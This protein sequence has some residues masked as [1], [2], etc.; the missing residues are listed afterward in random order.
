MLPMLAMAAGSMA[1]GAA[2]DAGLFG[3]P[4]Q[5]GFTKEDIQNSIRERGNEIDKFS[6]DLA[7]MRAQYMAQISGLQDAAYKRFGNDA[8]AGFAAKG[9]GVDS[10]AFSSALARAAIPMQADMYGKAFDT[11]EGNLKAVDAARGSLFTG[12]MGA[13]SAN[14]STPV[15][16]P[17]GAALGRFAGQA[18]MM[19]LSQGLQPAGVATTPAGAGG[20][21]NMGLPPGY[22]ASPAPTQASLIAGDWK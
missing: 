21:P 6:A 19:A 12:S 1:L 4:K 17:V 7:S 13:M 16:N 11:G 14:T 8:A 22:G 20:M 5:Y 2:S 10:G 3:K 9:M 15:P 18:G